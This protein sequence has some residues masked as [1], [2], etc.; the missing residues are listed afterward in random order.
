MMR[1]PNDAVLKVAGQEE[2]P[3]D[4]QADD[5]TEG[6]IEQFVDDV[7]KLTRIKA[8]IVLGPLGYTVRAF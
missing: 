7:A 1:Q 5:Q 2:L 4:S 3:A 6:Q 8:D